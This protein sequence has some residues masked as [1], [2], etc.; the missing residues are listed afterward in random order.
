MKAKIIMTVPARGKY[1][2]EIEG[3][4]KY[5]IFELLHSC[6]PEIGDL[7]VH[8]DFHSMGE[9]TFANLTQKCHMDVYVENILTSQRFSWESVL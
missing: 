5:V 6:K 2:A 7:I 8:H 1:A 9:E 4:G 3:E